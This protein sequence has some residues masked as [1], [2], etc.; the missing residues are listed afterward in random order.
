MKKL[1]L[2]FIYIMD[3]QL[4]GKHYILF[5]MILVILVCY[6]IFSIFLKIFLFYLDEEPWISINAYNSHDTADWKDLGLKYLLQIYR[7]YVYT[8]NKQ[9]LIE[10]WPTVKV[11][12]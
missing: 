10:I 5:L 6:S 2:G 9:F 4:I 12:I 3:D 1:N 7:D 11:R 8:E